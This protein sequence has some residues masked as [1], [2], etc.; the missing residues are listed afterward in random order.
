MRR[1][2]GILFAAT[3]IAGLALVLLGR[4]PRREP[5]RDR[6]RPEAP[7]VSISI[8]IRDGSVIPSAVTVP[9][10]R[11]LR[12]TVRNRGPARA[13]FGLAGYED[14]LSA[15]GID[16]GDSLTAE[17]AADRPGDDFAWLID[18]RPVGRFSVTGSHLV[19]GH[20]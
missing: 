20:R 3:V 6:A 9:K 5:A 19:E 16:P 11:L 10:D 1:S 7:A 17:F 4:S 8:E 13:R 14:R 18:G 2:Y 12:L 15:R